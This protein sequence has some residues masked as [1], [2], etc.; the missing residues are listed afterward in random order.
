MTIPPTLSI[1]TIIIPSCHWSAQHSKYPITSHH[2]HCFTLVQ[3][4]IMSHLNYCNHLSVPCFQPCPPLVSSPHSW[5]G[6]YSQPKS[7][8][9]FTL[10]PII[11][12]GLQGTPWL[13]PCHLST[14]HHLSL[15]FSYSALAV[16][17]ILVCLKH[18]DIPFSL[19][20]SHLPFP[21]PDTVPPDPLQ[22]QLTTLFNTYTHK[23]TNTHTQSHSLTTYPTTYL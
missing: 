17:A 9:P 6:G 13:G 8:N 12:H 3:G 14:P 10:R 1:Q 7:P 5:Q 18:T 4:T 15:L 2:L 16:P 20:T 21:Q 19:K 23:N 22:L 11:H